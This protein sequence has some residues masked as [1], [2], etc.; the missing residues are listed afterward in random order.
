MGP[1]IVADYSVPAPDCNHFPASIQGSFWHAGVMPAER[2]V[3]RASTA[4]VAPCL[5]AGL[6][7]R[8]P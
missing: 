3:E 2:S 5:G 1:E 7:P 6:F 4:Y 8:A